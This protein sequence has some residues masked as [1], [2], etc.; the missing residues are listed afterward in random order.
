[1]CRFRSSFWTFPEEAKIGDR[2]TYLVEGKIGA[3]LEKAVIVRYARYDGERRGIG[4]SAGQP[5]SICSNDQLRQEFV[6]KTVKVI[7]IKLA[8]LA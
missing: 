6:G 2:E 4:C 8:L 1:M 7:A 5:R 3:S